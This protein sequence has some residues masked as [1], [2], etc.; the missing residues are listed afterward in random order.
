MWPIWMLSEWTLWCQEMSCHMLHNKQNIYYLTTPVVNKHANGKWK[1]M[2]DETLSIFLLN[3]CQLCDFNC[4][5]FHDTDNLVSCVGS[6][7]WQMDFKL[8]WT[9]TNFRTTTFNTTFFVCLSY[10]CW[11]SLVKRDVLCSHV[12]H[13]IKMKFSWQLEAY[14]VSK[15]RVWLLVSQCNRLWLLTV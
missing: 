8:D 10:Y 4:L 14:L 7:W 15:G 1:I 2:F 13:W 3:Y 11:A 12:I 5:S 6:R 9:Q